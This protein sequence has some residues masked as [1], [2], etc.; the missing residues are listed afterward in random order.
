M[1]SRIEVEIRCLRQQ[2]NTVALRKFPWCGVEPAR[3]REEI[4]RLARLLRMKFA[5]RDRRA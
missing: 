4:Q 2:L 5:E 1:K 3:T